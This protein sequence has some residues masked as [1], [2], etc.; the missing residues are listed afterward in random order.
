MARI[1]TSGSTAWQNPTE[2]VGPGK[3]EGLAPDHHRTSRGFAVHDR[4]AGHVPVAQIFLDCQTDQEIRRKDHAA[5]PL[6]L[7]CFESLVVTTELLQFL[8]QPAP[9]SRSFSI[10]S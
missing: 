8:S 7:Q 10:T 1:S 4:L 3:D 9:F 6:N 5:H 2:R